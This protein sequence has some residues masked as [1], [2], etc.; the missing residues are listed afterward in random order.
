MVSKPGFTFSD[1]PN[2][3][4]SRSHIGLFVDVNF[5][6][7]KETCYYLN[8][9]GQKVDTMNMFYDKSY[10]TQITIDLTTKAFIEEN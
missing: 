5:N 8:S 1:D 3:S 4:F 6:T 10:G 7:N 2:L 9:K